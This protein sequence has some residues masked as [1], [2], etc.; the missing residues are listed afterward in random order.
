MSA[1]HPKTAFWLTQKTFD[2]LNCFA[3]LEERINRIPEE[4]DRGDVFEIFIEAYLA[5]QAIT[6]RT[7]H[8]VVGQIPL[9][10]RERFNLPSDSTGIDGI[11][12]AKGGTMVAYQVK[13]R[14]GRNL[15]FAEVAPFL[16]LTE[17]FSDRVIFTNAETLSDKAHQRSRWVS[18]ENF[19]ALPPEAFTQME[20]WL[21]QKPLP[22]LRAQ[23]DPNY[24]TQVLADIKTSLANHDGATVVMACGTGKTLVA[25]WA[26]EQAQPST[27]L[28][29]VP[30]LALLQQTLKEW[31]EHTRWGNRFSY[32]C[33]CSDPT[34]AL[35]DDGLIMDKT[36]VGFRVDT[37]PAEVRRFL[38]RKSG[39]VKIIF[40]TY[41]SSPV[42]AEGAK[43]LP[44][45]DLGI[46][47]EAHKTTGRE[48]GRFNFALSDKNIC[49]R[50][51]LFFT[52]TP[53]HID[54]RHRDKD[55]EFPVQSMDDESVYGPRAHTLSFAEAAR[56]G[57]I[58]SYK[59]ILSL[60]D[61]QMVSDFALNHG[62][63]LVKDDEISA[64]WVAHLVALKQ[65]VEKVDASKIITFHSRVKTAQNFAS[66][67]PQGIGYH[68]P[69]YQ[70][71][72][73]NGAQRSLE[74]VELIRAFTTQPKSILTNARCLT[75]GVNIPAVDMVAFIDPRQSRV[76]IAQAV[77]RAMR[78]PRGSTTKTLGYVVV[79]LFA[80]N[81]TNDSIEQA[82]HS[83]KFDAVA[84]VLNALQEH[85]EDLIDIIRE[86]R[87]QQ[88]MGAEFDPKRLHEKVEVIGPSVELARLTRSIDI[89]IVDRIGVGWDEWYG[90]LK[91]YKEREGHCRVHYQ[92]IEGGCRLGLWVNNQ[93][94]GEVSMTD[95]RRQRLDDLGFVWNVF[96]D[97]WE[98][99]FAALK[100]F[101][102]REGHC[103]VP[104]NQIEGDYRL[105]NWG[106]TQRMT[107]ETMIEERWRR[108]DALGFVWDPHADAWERGFA[109]LEFFHGR[110]GH[111]RV[112]DLHIEGDY[113]LGQW[114]RS[115]REK[116]VSMTAERRQ[117][118]DDLGFVWTPLANDWEQGF[119][120]LKEFYDREGH[121][122]VPQKHTESGYRLGVFV[123]IQRLK[124][125]SM[126]EGRR[127]RLD[128]LGLVWDPLANDWE[129]GFAALKVFRDREGHC[130]VPNKQT[131][132]DYQLGGWSGKQRTGKDSMPEERR[133]RLD[134]LGFVWDPI[135]DDWER[136][137]AAL[138]AFKDREGHCRVHYQ[139]TEGG[140]TLGNWVSVQ[141]KKKYSMTGD[142]RQRLDALGLD[143]DP[144][145]D[146]W[147]RGF[148]ALK[149]FHDREGHCSV[150]QRHTEG[151][152]RLSI[153]VNRQRMN[154]DSMADERKQRLDALGF[155]WDPLADA[156]A[157]AW[158]RGFAALK[159]FRDREGHC[160]VP[161][162]HTERDYS[163]G[164]WVKTQ[165]KK[166]DSV[167]GDRQQRLDALGF[168]WDP[169]A[170]A[171][172]HAWE[173]GFA[174]LK[175]FKD[176][177][178]H[179]RVHYLHTEGGCTLGNWVSVQ[180]K[181]KD[182]MTRDRRQRLDALGFVWDPLV[183]TSAQV[184]ERGFAALKVFHDR[185][186][187]CRVPARHTEG[188]YSL[189]SWGQQQRA[190]KDS[191][192]GERRQLLDAL[193]FVW[194]PFA[195]AWER[196]FAALKAF[197]DREGHC[198][199]PAKHTE[200]GYNIGTWVQHQRAL[201]DS[202]ARERRS[203]LDALGFVWDVVPNK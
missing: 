75:E 180:R 39:D 192:T 6:Q 135:A 194:D 113:R 44:P 198:Q 96:A 59:V 164:S 13:Y 125:D 16:G 71:R 202:M 161:I 193:G 168:V 190:L 166:K 201:K 97:D 203:R 48:G 63:T 152:Y 119:A 42:V 28:V 142:R 104:N 40:S 60:I 187:H 67:L 76:D 64:R 153:W 12:E 127:Q 29:L 200:Q 45:F 172:A 70:V 132:G 128:A 146:D 90:L 99:G 68:L 54:I 102:A 133:Q 157:H 82:V 124:K 53:R 165:R 2:G 107:R 3:E 158:E 175:A 91:R 134:A 55:G 106:A 170:D 89:E 159:V 25:L 85:D 58:C 139:H 105:G 118:L 23:P 17:K 186:G 163:L 150:S 15:T 18:R 137:F 22:V 199:V 27:V 77:G 115:Q 174:A 9:A 21:K 154:K 160:R 10:V 138:K 51:R 69:D 108:L 92:H 182:S 33:V 94:A 197:K 121:C 46:F 149:V 143:W 4:K 62:I 126:P 155:V 78:R 84:D 65:A 1:L 43:E 88:G 34:V 195:D 100:I 61:K 181:K 73:V 117:R 147:E 144:L 19:L 130:R 145:A 52:A 156:S 87:E 30:S 5:T 50:K 103:R 151:N 131:E 189:G 41:Q 56:K 141:R 116:Q 114:V 7:D 110:E 184:W 173:R 79:P 57:I 47:D 171:P 140:C 20:A 167:T 74:R 31:S 98:Q 120:A 112:T 196:G 26:A 122:R 136:G 32:L 35:K 37:D 24:Q 93:R 80:G 14:K 188:D 191:M 95:E 129:R 178:G 179:C 162:K 101:H 11:Y 185:E 36:E 111:C 169:L 38:E 86:M 109:A 66:S 72:H 81:G 83:E 177:E 183:D 49:I 148:S 176:R 8:W 123:S